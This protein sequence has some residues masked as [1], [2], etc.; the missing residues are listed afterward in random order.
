M[1][2][3]LR[4]VWVALAQMWRLECRRTGSPR[5]DGLAF[6]AETTARIVER[7]WDQ[8]RC[9]LP[10]WCFLP[11]PSVVHRWLRWKRSHR[12]GEQLRVE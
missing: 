2:N 7:S 12:G 1:R 4:S 9:Y 8:G 6:R 10:G 11:S 3:V 5:A